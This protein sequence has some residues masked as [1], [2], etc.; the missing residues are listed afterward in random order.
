M[1]EPVKIVDWPENSSPKLPLEPHFVTDRKLV[2]REEFG[3]G[4]HAVQ[5]NGQ[6]WI[7]EIYVRFSTLEF[8]DEVRWVPPEVE[9]AIQKVKSQQ[10][11][12][13]QCHG[14]DDMFRSRSESLPGDKD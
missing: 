13:S 12:Q 1:N 3:F 7:N 11:Q 8:V 10:Q 5:I 4:Q 6:V 2:G 14:P 9:E